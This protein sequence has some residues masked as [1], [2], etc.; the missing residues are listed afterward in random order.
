MANNLKNIPLKTIREYLEWKGCK[1][2]RSKGG[3]EIWA[4]RDLNRPIVIQSHITPV[5]EFIVR[6]ILRA[7]GTSQDD[8]IEF[9]KS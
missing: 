6:Q 9:L 1:M 4:H 3:H 8:F 5:P 2:I 7:F